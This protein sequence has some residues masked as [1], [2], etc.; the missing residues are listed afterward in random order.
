M[1]KLLDLMAGFSIFVATM[2]VFFCV[3]SILLSLSVLAGIPKLLKHFLVIH[4]VLLATDKSI[5]SSLA[6]KKT[7][8]ILC[9]VVLYYL[10]I[11]DFK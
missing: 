7:L 3:P 5:F 4:L 10:K 2:C 11:C 1:R 8:R 9:N 6:F